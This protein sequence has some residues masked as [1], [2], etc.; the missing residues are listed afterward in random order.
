MSCYDALFINVSANH[1]IYIDHKTFV[2]LNLFYFCNEKTSIIL[3]CV[4]KIVHKNYWILFC[5][6]QNYF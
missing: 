2:M 5:V 4:K 3:T 1:K 6:R